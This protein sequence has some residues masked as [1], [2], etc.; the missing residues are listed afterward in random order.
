MLSTRRIFN[1]FLRNLLLLFVVTYMQV[2][3]FYI[4]ETNHVFGV[5]NVKGN[6]WL[7][8]LVHVILFPVINNLYFYIIIIIL[9][10]FHEPTSD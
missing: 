4:S 3:Y 8:F 6:P 10:S 7:Q 1:F 5:H 2:I 9:F